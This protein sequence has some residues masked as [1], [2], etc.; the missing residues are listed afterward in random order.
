METLYSIRRAKLKERRR[1][2]AISRLGKAVEALY[3][4]GASRV[5]VFGSVLKPGSFNERSD[6][7]IAVEGIPE[8]RRLEVE[9]ELVDIF[10]DIEFDIIF[11]EERENVRPEIL[12]RIE[13]EG[14]LWRP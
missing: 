5:I 4:D 10:G 6:V 14:E 7:D 2:L 12:E 13:K 1:S 3:S 8:G 11:L 9:G